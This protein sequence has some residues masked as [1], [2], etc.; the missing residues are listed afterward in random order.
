MDRMDG[1]DMKRS[2]YGLMRCAGVLVIMTLWVVLPSNV[3]A[4]W[5]LEPYAGLTYTSQSDADVSANGGGTALSG[6]FKDVDYDDSITIGIR[7]GRW[8]ESVEYLGFALDIFGFRPDVKAQTATFS[9]T[10]SATVGSDIIVATGSTQA[11]I[12]EIDAKVLGFSGDVMLRLLPA[13]R[14]PTTFGEIHVY[15]TAGPAVYLASLKS[16]TDTVFGFKGGAGFTWLINSQTGFFVEYRYTHF[17]PDFQIKSGSVKM[18]IDS[19]I[20]THHII[21]GLSFRF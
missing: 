7:L 14:T 10:G 6:E 21:A 15:V 5:F 4:E 11:L 3:G 18:N 2:K 16:K 1:P 8:L 20:S 19:D 9:G 12:G 17:S 13:D